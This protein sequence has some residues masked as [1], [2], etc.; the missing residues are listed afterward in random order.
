MRVFNTKVETLNGATLNANINSAA[1]SLYQMAG[2][3][4]QVVITGTPTGTL[5]LQA[6]NDPYISTLPT[7]TLP[8]NWTDVTG[9][10]FSVSAAG[11][12]MWNVAPSVYNWVR[13]VYTDGSGGASTAVV[14]SAVLNGKNLGE[15]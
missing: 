10:T 2:Y 14:A 13:V 1:I 12:V 8:T 3:A 15:R 11:N 9:S 4:I 5:K 6:S 7:D